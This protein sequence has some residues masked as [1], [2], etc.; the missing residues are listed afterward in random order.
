MA[1]GGDSDLHLYFSS[2]GSVF[3]N[4]KINPSPGKTKQNRGKQ[5]TVV[6]DCNYTRRNHH[7][8]VIAV[9]VGESLKKGHLEQAFAEFVEEREVITGRG[10]L[11]QTA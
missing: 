6:S 11:Q 2:V 9:V 1:I 7:S 4:K 8:P 3:Q 5:K 10:K